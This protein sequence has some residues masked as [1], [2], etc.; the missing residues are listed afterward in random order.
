MYTPCSLLGFFPSPKLAVMAGGLWWLRSGD[1][2][3][4]DVQEFKKN[5]LVP[6]QG[7]EHLCIISRDTNLVPEKADTSAEDGHRMIFSIEDLYSHHYYRVMK[8][9]HLIM[10]RYHVQFAGPEGFSAD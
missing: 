1:P 10:V 6:D 2:A 8:P 7:R 4:L 5:N 9:A 3:Y